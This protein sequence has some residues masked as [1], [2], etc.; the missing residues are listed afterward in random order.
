[1]AKKLTT[2]AVENT[3]P[4][5]A[6]REISDGGSGLWL[7]VHPSGKKSW[8]VRYRFERRPAKLTL[9]ASSLADARRQAAEALHEVAQGRDPATKKLT[10]RQAKAE[11]ARDTVESL[12]AEFLEKHA[13]RKTR[14]SSW[15]Q[16][17]R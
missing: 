6:R 14:P 3:K 2:V 4:G 7:I 16:C 5:P 11:R 15:K 9:A 10:A 1:M 8:A 13:K 12:A 17:E